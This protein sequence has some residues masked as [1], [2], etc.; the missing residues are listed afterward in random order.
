MPP[1]VTP[2]YAALLTVLLIILSFRVINIRKSDRISLGDGGNPALLRRIRAQA[3]LVEYA[4]M[5]LVLL[6]IAELQGRPAALLHLAGLMLLAGRLGHALALSAPHPRLALRVA[7]M[8]LTFSA[9]TLLA[10]MI[11]PVW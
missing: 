2:I 9:L 1:V 6:L 10:L 8:A 3:N 7:G 11:L 4:P 5:G